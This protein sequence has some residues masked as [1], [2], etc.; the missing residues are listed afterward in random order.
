MR[1]LRPNGGEPRLIDVRLR[2][3]AE[4]PARRLGRLTSH[5]GVPLGL[6]R[7]GEQ[8]KETGAVVHDLLQVRLGQPGPSRLDVELSDQGVGFGRIRLIVQDPLQMTFGRL[9]G[10]AA[11]VRSAQQAAGLPELG[12]A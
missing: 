7:V 12:G 6:V 4:G 11:E 3:A 2:L 5:P 9:E 8:D 10:F 1:R